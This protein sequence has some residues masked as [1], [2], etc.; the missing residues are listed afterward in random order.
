MAESTFLHPGAAVRAAGIHEGLLVADFGAGS[1]FFTRAAA[2]EVGDAGAVWAVDQNRDLLPRIK[3]L[4]AGEGLNNVEVMHGDI[5]VVGGTNLPENHFDFVILANVLFML[6]ERGEC[7]AEMR[8]VLKKTGRVLVIDWK[9][10][11][12]GLGPHP[13][14]VITQEAAQA[15][16]EK[17]GFT[18]GPAVPAGEYHWG[19][20]VRKKAA[21]G[22]L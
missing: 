13:D 19:F 2:R 12:G 8:R 22:A 17:H 21:Q 3:N 10:S 9:D 20:V 4:S 15:L 6:S 16:F 7:M 11:F 1:G 14:H 5:E 18:M